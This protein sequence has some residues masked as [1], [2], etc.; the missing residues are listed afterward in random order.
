MIPRRILLAAL[1]ILTATF[2]SCRTAPIRNIPM[3]SIPTTQHM[4]LTEDEVAGAIIRGGNKAGW[5][6]RK[7]EPGLI[8]GTIQVR[9]HEAQVDVRYS[10]TTWNIAYRDSKN[11]KF[12]GEKIHSNYNKWVSRLGDSIRNQIDEDMEFH[13][14]RKN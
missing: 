1:V 6:M 12:N 4:S 8:V 13:V 11:L 3:N 9:T 7:V 2:V 5:S 10:A 14:Q